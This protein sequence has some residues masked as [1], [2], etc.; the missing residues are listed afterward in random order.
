M[1]TIHHHDLRIT[2]RVD[3]VVRETN[4]VTLTCRI[5]DEIV[6][7]VEEEGAHVLVVDLP[8]AVGLVLRYD[9]PAVLG[10]ELV[11]VRGFLEEDPPARHVAGSQQQVL[12]QA[13]LHG[14]VLAVDGRGVQRGGV[15]AARGAEVGV[16]LAHAEVARALLRV[17]LRLAAAPREPVLTVAAALTELLA[18]VLR[19]QARA[20]AVARLAGVVARREIGRAHV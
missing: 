5:H 3:R 10:D 12:V 6:V 13:S 15:G 20:Q 17:A 7:E 16:A 2:V 19:L 1:V 11:L 4:L 8:A 14:H 9:L 18:E